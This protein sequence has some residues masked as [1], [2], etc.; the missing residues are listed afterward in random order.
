M[1]RIDG[2]MT[3]LWAFASG[4]GIPVVLSRCSG[5]C[6][7]CGYCLPV[8]ASIPVMAML[9]VWS[10]AQAFVRRVLGGPRPERATSPPKSDCMGGAGCRDGIS[11][12]R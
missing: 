9:L 3:F 10:R 5:N 12:K 11:V 4:L 6:G 2:R 7:V 8:T 1:A